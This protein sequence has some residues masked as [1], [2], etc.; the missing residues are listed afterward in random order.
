MRDTICSSRPPGSCVL[1]M[2]LYADVTS[3]HV[4]GGL[5]PD[6]LRWAFT[7][8]H[9]GYWMPLVW[10]SH[11]A[12][13]Q[14]YG[15]NAGPHHVTNLLLHIA[16]TL[17]LFGFLWRVTGSIGR[18][19]FVAA[20]FAVHPLHVESVAWITERKDVLSTLFWILTMWAYV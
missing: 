9:A 13:V 6:A 15:M 17:L 18:S 20:L 11:M 7:S 12:D 16:N 8:A 14:L 2:S 1:L 10:L 3:S 5:T 19:G 4:A